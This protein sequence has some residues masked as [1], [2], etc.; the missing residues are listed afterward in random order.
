MENFMVHIRIKYMRLYGT[1][2]ADDRQAL[3]KDFN[4]PDSP[5]FCFLL[6]TRA[7]VLGLNLQTAGTAIISHSD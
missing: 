3:L 1:T 5:F 2:K 4:K 6:S 7:G